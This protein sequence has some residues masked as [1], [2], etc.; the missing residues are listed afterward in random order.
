MNKNSREQFEQAY[1]EDNG[2]VDLK[3]A[4]LPKAL[5]ALTGMRIGDSYA[6]PKVARAWYWWKRARA[7]VLVDDNQARDACRYR[8]MRDN[9]WPGACRQIGMVRTGQEHNWLD[10]IEAD[11]LI[12]QQIA[13]DAGVQVAT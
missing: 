11:R 13:L 8:W 4:V 2:G 3:G 5:E 9:P 1:C 7:V 6:I 10:G 12:D